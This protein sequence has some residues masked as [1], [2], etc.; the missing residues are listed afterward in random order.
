MERSRN[1][2][3]SDEARIIAQELGNNNTIVCRWTTP[4]E[5]DRTVHILPTSS[6][7]D[8]LFIQALIIELG[9]WSLAAQVDMNDPDRIFVNRIKNSV[10]AI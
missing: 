3:A 10:S 9:A 6:K 8:K 2:V 1:L 5:G 4:K 7:G